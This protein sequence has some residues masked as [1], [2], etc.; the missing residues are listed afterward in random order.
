MLAGF[1]IF[2][3]CMAFNIVAILKADESW[4]RAA[5]IVSIFSVALMYYVMFV[6]EELPYYV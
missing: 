3:A 4:S 1:L 2:I 5:F 6:R